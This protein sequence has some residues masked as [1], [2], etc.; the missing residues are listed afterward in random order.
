MSV[1]HE[2]SSAEG[3]VGVRDTRAPS[4]DTTA[5][6]TAAK[7]NSVQRGRGGRTTNRVPILSSR[8]VD[9]TLRVP[10]VQDRPTF[11]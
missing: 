3:R 2:L 9:V 7:E 11:W 4:R 5:G 6:W 8:D 10:R 1:L